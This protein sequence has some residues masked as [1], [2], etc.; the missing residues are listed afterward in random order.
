[1]GR[2]ENRSIEN[3]RSK[4]RGS[5]Y[6]SP[7]SFSFFFFF[8]LRRQN[9][10]HKI[11]RRVAGNRIGVRVGIFAKK[12]KTKKEKERSNLITFL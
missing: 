3:Y 11:L 5:N 10:F 9:T 12:E 1:M 7:F 8:F 6:L 2:E 4:I